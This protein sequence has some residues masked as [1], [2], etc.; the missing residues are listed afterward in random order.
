MAKKSLLLAVGIFALSLQLKA[1]EKKNILKWFPA[2][3]CTTFD[4]QKKVSI[5]DPSITA[6][7]LVVDAVATKNLMH[8]ISALPTQGEK[9]IS[10]KDSAT[11]LDIIFTCGTKKETITFI[12]GKIKTPAT[13]FYSGDNQEAKIIFQEVSTLLMAEYGKPVLYI[14]H[15][16]QDFAD[17]KITYNGKEFVDGA[18][19]TVS[20]T[21]ELFLVKDKNGVEQSVVVSSGQKPPQPV[22]F[23]VKGHEYTLYTYR[24]PT[25]DDLYPDHFQINK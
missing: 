18:P 17:F 20:A 10:F 7:K 25:G 3:K 22:K 16:A 9:A 15:L 23:K 5:S 19:A 14:I 11:Q 12:D 2:E 8:K 6:Q 21:R 1:Q 4:I 24:S 13:N